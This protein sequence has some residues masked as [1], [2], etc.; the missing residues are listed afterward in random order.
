MENNDNKIK[1]TLD[2]G[3]EPSLDFSSDNLQNKK[4]DKDEI[5]LS[6]DE[7]KMVDD[8]VKQIDLNNSNV[9]LQYGVGAQ[10]K[11][12]SLDRKSVV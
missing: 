5:N 4:L 12:A 8:F 7:R 6:P 11:I 1:L 2:V 9:I 10:K 3:N